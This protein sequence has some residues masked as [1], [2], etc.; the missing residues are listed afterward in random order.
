MW[1]LLASAP[2]VAKVLLA[3]DERVLWP[4]VVGVFVFGLAGV[5]LGRRERRADGPAAEPDASTEG[6]PSAAPNTAP[7]AAGEPDGTGA[8]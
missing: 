5:W 2:G 4:I 1:L 8:E 3:P 6:G 7:N